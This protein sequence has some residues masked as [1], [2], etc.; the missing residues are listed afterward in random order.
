MSDDLY[1]K[2]YLKPL[3]PVERVRLQIANL[4]GGSLN[5]RTVTTADLVI[6]IFEQRETDGAD[7]NDNF[8]KW[9]YYLEVELNVEKDMGKVHFIA[10][11]KELLSK[12][13][14]SDFSVVPS[15]DFEDELK[16]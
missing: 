11:I 15:C 1:C 3:A 5:I 8:L 6:D 14:R 2:I 10:E 9:P 4:T 16:G 13:R 12:L 7:R